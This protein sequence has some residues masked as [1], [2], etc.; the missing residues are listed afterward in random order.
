MKTK[1]AAVLTIRAPGKMN[2]K[3]RRMIAGWLRRQ[4]RHFLA[5]GD[6]YTKGN[7]KARY[8]YT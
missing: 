4:A 7:F 5:R 8:L 2:K 6:L 3:G 1:T